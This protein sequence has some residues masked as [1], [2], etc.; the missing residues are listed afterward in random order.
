VSAAGRY[1]ES[2]RTVAVTRSFAASR[3]WR[4][5]R[6]ANADSTCPPPDWRRA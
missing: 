6:A 3:A 2:S 1:E 4:S 5:R